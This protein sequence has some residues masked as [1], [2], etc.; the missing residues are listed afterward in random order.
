MDD[1]INS[2]KSDCNIIYVYSETYMYL[3]DIIGGGE[4][5]RNVLIS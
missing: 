3:S 5:V 4:I 1:T 2:R